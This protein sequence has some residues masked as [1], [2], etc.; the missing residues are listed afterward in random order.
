VRVAQQA[1]TSTETICNENEFEQKPRILE[2]TRVIKTEL[3]NIDSAAKKQNIQLQT[4]Q[5][6]VDKLKD[7]RYQGISLLCILGVGVG[8]FLIIT[9]ASKIGVATIVGSF[10]TLGSIFLINAVSGYLWLIGGVLSLILVGA[11]LYFA[12]I[13]IIKNRAIEQLV[14][15]VQISKDSTDKHQIKKEL[16]VIQ[17]DT[18][19]ALVKEIKR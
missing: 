16:N 13:L 15:S 18:T 7:R 17:S 1:N 3:T 12:Y 14:A 9:G 19:K 2:N 6:Q 11:L 5:K 10:A 4:T 8:T